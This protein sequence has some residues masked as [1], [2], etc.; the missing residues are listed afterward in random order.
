MALP[1]LVRCELCRISFG[2]RVWDAG[3]VSR[4][5]LC[6]MLRW[7]SAVFL[8]LWLWAFEAWDAHQGAA[9]LMS[10][11]LIQLFVSFRRLVFNTQ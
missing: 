9:G 4:F 3:F 2:L 11:L 8:A 5:W 10:I 6:R 7:L 1:A